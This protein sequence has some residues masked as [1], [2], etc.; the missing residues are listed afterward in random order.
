[1]PTPNRKTYIVDPKVQYKIVFF[2]GGIA[3]ICA[4]IIMVV[5][6]N[7]LVKYSPVVEGSGDFVRDT[8]IRV[9]IVVGVMIVYF[10]I[11]GVVLTHRVAGPI[12]KLQEELKKYLNGEEIPPITFRK[13]DEFQELPALINRIIEKNK[14]AS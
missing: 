2:L 6:Y 7:Q 9:A 14:K 8:I 1:M 10:V 3:L 4:C 13:D 5:T 11:A 12:F